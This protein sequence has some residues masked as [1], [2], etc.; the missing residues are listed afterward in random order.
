MPSAV[1]VYRA[2]SI[3]TKRKRRSRSEIDALRVTISRVVADHHPM[4]VRQVF[5]QLVKLR[6]IDKTERAY[7][8]V[9][10]R[11]LTKM[12]LEGELPW[13][14]IA[15][16]TRWMRKPTTYDSI[17]DALRETAASYRRAL[18]RDHNVYVEVWLEKEALAGVL[19]GVTAEWDVPLM[20]TRGF[21]SLSYLYSA[22]ETIAAMNRPTYLYYFGDYDP[23]GVEIDRNIERRLR[24]FVSPLDHL[25][26]FERVAVTP[27]QIVE[28]DLPTRPTKRT[29][30]G[31]DLHRGD[32]VEVDALDPED[33]RSLVQDRIFRHIDAGR[34]RATRAAEESE[35]ELLGGLSAMLRRNEV[36]AAS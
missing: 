31:R 26:H 11:L 21:A 18:W 32:S 29:S 34:L 12:R 2:S 17:E 4:T 1:D 15:D 27:G 35:R 5:Y 8:D 23:S 19:L 24:E 10:V 20:V 33:L 7:N 6:L 3:T 9:V 13:Q 16:S 25:I 36:L 22:A 14:W 28:Y 30:H